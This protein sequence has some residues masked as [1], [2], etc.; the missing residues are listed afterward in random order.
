MAEDLNGLN[1]ADPNYWQ[2]FE[3]L[4][5][6]PDFIKNH[7]DEFKEGVSVDFDSS[8]MSS[9]SR[10]KFLALLGASAALAGTAC[11]DYRDKGEIIPYN[12]KPE[13]V[14]LGK[15]NYYASTCSACPNAC[16]TLIKTREGRPIKIDG[17]PDHP[18]SKGKICAQGQASIMSL[19][20][21]DRLKNPKKKLDRRFVDYS[22]KSA[23]EEIIFD[24]MNSG[25]KEIAIITHKIISPTSKKVL[26][27]FVSKY[28][29][30]RIY[31]YEVFNSSVR[32]SAWKKC[33]GSDEFPAIKWNEAEIIV[34]LDGDFLGESNNK[35]ENARLFSESRDI[36]NKRFNRLYVIEGNI[37]ITGMAA[38]YRLRL[39][40]DMQL[41]FVLSLIDALN[42]RGAGIPINSGGITLE[43]FANQYG[44]NPGTLKTII[45]DLLKNKG[46]SI[47]YAGNHLAEDVHIAVN[48]LNAALGNET[49]YNFETGPE[50]VHPLSSLLELKEL[51]SRMSSGKVSVAI[52]LNSN[53]V[54]DFASDLKYADALS[55]VDTVVS[56]IELENE[57]SEFSNYCLPVNNQLESWGDA[58]ARTGIYSLKQPVISPLYDS[59][60]SESIILTWI[61]T[62]SS[63]YDEFLYHKYLMDNWEKN[64]Y[65]ETGIN[66]E[67]KRFWY[68]ALHDG[69]V[70]VPER[71]SGIGS[72]S[73]SAGQQIK[74][75]EDSE[76]FSLLIKESYAVRDGR[77]A[78]NGWLQELPH[79]VS[80]VVWDNYAAISLKTAN[81]LGLNSN[82]LIKVSTGNN[83]LTI[84]VFIQPGASDNSITIESGY[85]RKNG[86]TVG[87]GIGFNCNILLNT[88]AGLSPWLYSDV[89][90]EK[91]EG[92]YK[93]VT[94]QTV[95]AFN[96]G[97]TKDLPAKRG[98]IKEGTVQEYLNDP[99]F[100]N[101]EEKHELTSV[102][103]FYDYKGVKWG[104]S[105]DMNRCLG[106]G[107]C[108]VACNV[109]NNIPVVGKDQVD[110]GREM[111]WI[112]IDRYYS[113][114]PEDPN[115]NN[116][117]MV[118][119]HCDHAPCE[120]VCPVVA[121]THSPDGLNQMVYNRCVGTRYCSNNCPYKVRRFNYFNFRDH[122]R[123]GFQE[124]PV[125]ALLM[126]PEVTVRSRGVMEKCTFCIQRI[127]DARAEA[128][129]EGKQLKG[130]DVKTACQE[131]C[132][133]SA[134]HFGD[135]NNNEE[136]FSKYRN[137][138]LGYHLLEE[139]NIRP[140][141]TYIAKLKNKN[142]ETA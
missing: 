24:L 8:V 38:D 51:T 136:E 30:A 39:R 85:G 101:K 23:N 33:Y 56:F 138:E 92:S 78:N 13:E 96:D 81:N 132:I 118:C 65:P 63:T 140:N 135:I 52:H 21:P 60:Q 44:L 111:H 11:S 83:S 69:V 57:T 53:P 16:G 61:S 90:V 48:H 120:N 139:L 73:N 12:R 75:A 108:V 94:A 133:T 47:V 5:N 130:S 67:F 46:K 112:R 137:H 134:I 17:N 129:K 93:L 104:M 84:P 116:Q 99:Q 79:P 76:S 20:D 113:G 110:N 114:S 6:D 36:I 123:N 49:I 10:R 41:N 74:P 80:K 14:T 102:N 54:Y 40:P 26:D 127:S 77:F 98:I 131:A 97:L 34:S 62:E 58:K 1:T 42:K 117:V 121:T 31:S 88:S 119:Q 142:S 18:I 124:S 89:K 2:S 29:S 19:Y 28:P 43:N 128:T 126:N 37:S 141:V 55:N 107:E 82:D 27:E 68:S 87:T 3:E 4:Y 115:V 103:P 95:Y 72:I 32:N 45:S 35:I 122:F 109:E 70:I 15:A 64:L 71:T 66:L 25:N 100:L 125:F 59:R 50:I 9:L 86:G 22:W 91:I 105:V 106:C 7:G